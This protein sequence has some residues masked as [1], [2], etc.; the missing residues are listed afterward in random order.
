MADKE[1]T[2]ALQSPL[3]NYWERVRLV[4]NGAKYFETAGVQYCLGNHN[5]GKCGWCKPNMRRPAVLGDH[6]V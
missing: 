4:E 5:W 3:D 6:A 1:N 2:M